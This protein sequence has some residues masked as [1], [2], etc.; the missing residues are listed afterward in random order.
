[1]VSVA[2]ALKANTDSMRS[3]ETRAERRHDQVISRLDD[4]RHGTG[5]KQP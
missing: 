3:A 4:L 2:N 1:L 5:P